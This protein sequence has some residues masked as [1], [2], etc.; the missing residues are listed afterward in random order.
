MNETILPLYFVCNSSIPAT[1]G[2]QNDSRIEGVSSGIVLYP[3]VAG[4]DLPHQ[5]VVPDSN[6]GWPNIGPNSVLSSRRWA[7]ISQTYIAVWGVFL[8]SSTFNITA[9]LYW[10]CEP[11]A[12][13]QVRN[14][15]DCACAGN[16]GN[17]FPATD[18]KGN[19][20]LAIPACILAR[21]WCTCRDACRNR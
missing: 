4:I 10:W 19:R 3:F 11:W 14:I 6:V 16:A 13:Y 5:G 12:S 1:H 2:T 17:V 7:N 9:L 15:A 20:Q 8:Q 18:F 21:A